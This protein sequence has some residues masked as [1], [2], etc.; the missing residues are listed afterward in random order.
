MSNSV[1]I[2]VDKPIVTDP[3][4]AKNPPKTVIIAPTKKE[5]SIDSTTLALLLA[6]VGIPMVIFFIV[7]FVA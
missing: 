5:G 2:V 7:I 3:P 1:P 4:V 6:Y